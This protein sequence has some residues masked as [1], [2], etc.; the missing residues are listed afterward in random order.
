MIL[1]YHK[2]PIDGEHVR[3]RSPLWGRLIKDP[4]EATLRSWQ[5]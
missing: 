3:E 4:G 1:G 5:L 2:N